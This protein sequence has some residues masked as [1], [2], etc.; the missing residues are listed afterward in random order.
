MDAEGLGEAS[1]SVLNM[2]NLRCLLEI[3][4]ELLGRHLDNVSLQILREV[5]DGD[6]CI[7]MQVAF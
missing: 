1:S 6:K 5:C 4:V 3:Q 2:Q 7:S